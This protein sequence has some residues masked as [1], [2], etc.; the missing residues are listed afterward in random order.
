MKGSW[1]CAP[2]TEIMSRM[3]TVCGRLLPKVDT[4]EDPLF[5]QGSDISV[6]TYY[7]SRL[8][9]RTSYPKPFGGEQ[10]TGNQGMLT[11]NKAFEEFRINLSETIG[12]MGM[13][14][15]LSSYTT[16]LVGLVA[17][18]TVLAF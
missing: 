4:P 18:V 13:E 3:R 15:A 7:S 17:A 14:G 5:V 6:M 12:Q 10:S 9:G 11:E 8:S 2:P 1:I 16:T